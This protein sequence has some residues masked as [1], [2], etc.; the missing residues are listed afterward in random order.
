MS[1]EGVL[2][3][4]HVMPSVNYES[5]NP[6]ARTWGLL[7]DSM[8]LSGMPAS[9]IVLSGSTELLHDQDVPINFCGQ[10][11][12]EALNIGSNSPG[13]P[14]NNLELTNVTPRPIIPTHPVRSLVGLFNN[15]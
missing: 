13:I 2:K 7:E 4:T 12:N 8:P 1:D 5:T 10:N 15:L 6:P 14:R 9:L 3:D 11:F